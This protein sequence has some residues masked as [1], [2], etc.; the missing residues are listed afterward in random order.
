MGELVTT[1]SLKGVVEIGVLM[2]DFDLVKV[3]MIP[4]D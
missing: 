2:V 1:A 3:E 4:I